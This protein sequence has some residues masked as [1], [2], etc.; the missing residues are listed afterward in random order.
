MTVCWEQT[1]YQNVL[2]QLPN[3]DHSIYIF[4]V[5]KV[6]IHLCPNWNDILKLVFPIMNFL[7]DGCF[8]QESNDNLGFLI[9]NLRSFI[10]K[11]KWCYHELVYC[12]GISVSHLCSKCHNHNPFSFPRVLHHWKRLSVR[13]TYMTV[14]TGA[15]RCFY[16]SCIWQNF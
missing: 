13:C 2:F 11:F 6:Y 3:C 7:T 5:H 9:V 12:Y 15:A 10:W 4:Y 8:W 1:F 16:L 14:A